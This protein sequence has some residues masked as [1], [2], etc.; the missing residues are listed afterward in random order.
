VN[1]LPDLEEEDRRFQVVVVATAPES[2][3]LTIQP[4]PA[5]VDHFE[6]KALLS[7][8]TS[9]TKY[10][11]HRGIAP[12]IMTPDVMFCVV[13]R[14]GAMLPQHQMEVLTPIGKLCQPKS[15]D[16]LCYESA[17]RIV[18]LAGVRKINVAYSG[19]IDSTL[20]LAELLKIAPHDQLVV[21][22]DQHS[23]TEYPD[24][25]TKHIQNKLTTRE[26]SFYSDAPLLDSVKDGIVVTGHLMDPVFGS[27][28][29]SAL[30]PERLTQKI[31]ELFNEL[32]IYTCE[33][34]TKLIQA[35]PRP[36]VDVKDFLWWMDYTLNYQ[37]EQLMWLYDSEELT[38]EQNFT[39]FGTGAD[40]NDYAV[41][42]AAEEKYFGTD[43][44][45]HKMALKKQLF[46]FTG[47]AEYT[48]NKLKVPSWRKYRT[49][50]QRL[51][52]KPIS[53]RTDW[54]RGYRVG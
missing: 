41:S 39:H 47:D 30:S 33:M 9:H 3:N 37:S 42:T 13:D 20:L 11:H 8:K 16:T 49:N 25:Y 6:M 28:M 2:Y 14:T 15:I 10:Y 27:G 43:F 54:S 21:M 24:F 18:T 48:E 45:Q 29:Y 38:L 1:S 35:C 5:Q 53:I 31:P 36:L 46:T 4:A 19:G 23:I 51:Q 7:G 26:M 34:Y 17:Q 44:R 32:N 52:T 40:W 50:T 22:M 12:Y